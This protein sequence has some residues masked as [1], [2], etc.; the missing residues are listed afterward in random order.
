[1]DTYEKGTHWRL[2]CSTI[3]Q[4]KYRMVVFIYLYRLNA[5]PCTGFCINALKIYTYD[6]HFIFNEVIPWTHKIHFTSFHADTWIHSLPYMRLSMKI[7]LFQSKTEQHSVDYI[8]GRFY[9]Y[10]WELRRGTTEAAA[11]I[12]NKYLQ[13][14]SVHIFATLET[15]RMLETCSYSYQPASKFMLK[16][17]GLRLFKYGLFGGTRIARSV[18]G[19]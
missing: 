9:F 19:K 12:S 14:F 6:L 5:A 11:L 8:A 1:M 4:I 18:A 7:L 15:Q 13:Y 17:M 3:A 10:V 16:H 2:E